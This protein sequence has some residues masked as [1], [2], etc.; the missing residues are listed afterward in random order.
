[1][2]IERTAN[3]MTNAEIKKAAYKNG[4]AFKGYWKCE[5]CEEEANTAMDAI[6][7]AGGGF[8]TWVNVACALK[9][10]KKG[11]TVAACAC[12]W[13]KNITIKFTKVEKS[14]CPGCDSNLNKDGN[15]YKPDCIETSY[16]APSPSTPKAPKQAISATKVCS[17][18]GCGNPVPAGRKTICDPCR[19]TP[20]EPVSSNI[21]M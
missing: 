10:H 2:T 17:R 18:P 8:P 14:K 20:K 6:G 11:S 1:M 3:P 19:N 15:C 16:V 9:F 21:V 7:Y 5:S 13:R 12:G 4:Y